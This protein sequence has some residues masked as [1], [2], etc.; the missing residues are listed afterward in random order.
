[1]FAN[2]WKP[3]VDS[4]VD[5]PMSGSSKTRSDWAPLQEQ[6]HQHI[7]TVVP[8]SSSN[9]PAP[10][11]PS[12]IPFS[13][14]LTHPH[15]GMSAM[16]SRST[17]VATHDSLWHDIVN[18][19]DV[20]CL[21]GTT[22]GARSTGKARPAEVRLPSDQL[23]QIITAL[24]DSRHNVLNNPG[25]RASTSQST[26]GNTR[27]MADEVARQVSFGHV[28]V[29]AYPTR[30]N[31]DR[32]TSDVTMH[33]NCSSFPD[34]TFNDPVSGELIHKTPVKPS[35]LPARHDTPFLDLPNNDTSR[36]NEKASVT[37]T[38]DP[39][40][41]FGMGKKRGRSPLLAV[42][43]H[44]QSILRSPEP[45]RK[46]SRTMHKDAGNSDDKENSFMTVL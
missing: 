30:S 32:T 36:K 6:S 15:Q 28:S 11:V 39:E 40:V 37:D 38:S 35:R 43:Q 45:K 34:C 10:P 42:D 24:S 41:G 14:S 16:S 20:G 21:D 3:P 12:Q 29:E 1:M 44:R 33:A 2:P 5:S 26:T 22:S 7:T 8:R 19:M 25:L 46:S 23:R 18:P 9:M 4:R 13:L 31:R 17:S 27:P